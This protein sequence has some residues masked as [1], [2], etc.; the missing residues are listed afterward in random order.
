MKAIVKLSETLSLEIQEQDDKETLVKAILLMNHP[1]RCSLCG[2][3]DL[4]FTA[5]KDKDANLYVKISCFKC[6]SSASLG[7]YRA[8]GNFWHNE[9]KQF[10]K[11]GETP[12]VENNDVNYG[13]DEEESVD[14]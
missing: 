6:S 8:G 14:F 3:T 10:V 4:H 2:N 12:K 1:K 7:S 11:K 9:F 5:N 13:A